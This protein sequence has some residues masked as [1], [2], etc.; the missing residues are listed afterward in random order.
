MTIN[1]EYEIGAWVKAYN[2]KITIDGVSNRL[3][4]VTGKI[5]EIII[6]R[7]IVTKDFIYLYRLEDGSI[8]NEKSLMR[9]LN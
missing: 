7:D 1:N 5:K 9:V 3:E 8:Y 6:Q 4:L 2:N